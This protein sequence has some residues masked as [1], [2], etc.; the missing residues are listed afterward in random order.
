MQDLDAKWSLHLAKFCRGKSPGYVYIVYKPRRRPKM[1]KVWLASGER[2]RCSNKAKM[3]NP[4]KFAGVPQTSRPISA[5]SGPKFAIL[6]DVWKRYCYLASLFSIVNTLLSCEDIARQSCAMGHR[7][8]FLVSFRSC[9][10]SE[11]VQHISDQHS[12]FALGPHHV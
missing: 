7:W 6:W 10:F 8:R 11:P 5:V 3:W 9:I 1:C 2:R 4:L 12:E